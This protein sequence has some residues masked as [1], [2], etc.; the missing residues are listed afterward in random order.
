MKR[1]QR[2]DTS[3]VAP[4]P[5]VFNGSAQHFT[6][7]STYKILSKSRWS[8]MK[9]SSQGWSLDV[10]SGAVVVALGHTLCLLTSH[11]PVLILFFLSSTKNSFMDVCFLL[12]HSASLSFKKMEKVTKSSESVFN[13]PLSMKEI[14][15]LLFQ[16]EV[17]S[18]A[19][20]V[21][22]IFG[23]VLNQHHIT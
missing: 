15:P 20:I 17:V 12:F 11:K 23:S 1:L 10:H 14:V 9:Y 3:A 5:G 18:V 4:P 6:G 8:R 22:F 19:L 16:M 13:F 2:G 7:S 21:T